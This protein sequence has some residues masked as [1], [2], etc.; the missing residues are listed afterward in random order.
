MVLS[1]SK[2]DANSANTT[3]PELE[4][5]RRVPLKRRSLSRYYPSKAQSFTCFQELLGTPYGTS[6]LALSK[7]CSS[8][9]AGMAAAATAPMQL[10]RGYRS[11]CR[12]LDVDLP[13]DCSPLTSPSFSDDHSDQVH[14]SAGTS[15]EFAAWRSAHAV[16]DCST[17]GPQS[18]RRPYGGM[19]DPGTPIGYDWMSHTADLCT[20]LQLTSLSAPAGVLLGTEEGERRDFGMPQPMHCRC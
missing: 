18:W 15:S 9:A 3:T 14:S 19:S 5:V 12:S 6:A 16:P 20:A 2:S 7:D 13:S 17:S 10:P 1:S 11:G 4:T 8:R